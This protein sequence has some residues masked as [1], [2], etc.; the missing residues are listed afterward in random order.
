MLLIVASGGSS[1]DHVILADLHIH[2]VTGVGI[3]VKAT[4]LA[5][6]DGSTM[7]NEFREHLSNPELEASLFE[8]EL[9]GYEVVDPLKR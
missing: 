8:V 7:R 3:N 1:S 5:F 2:H 4:E 9:E 6:P